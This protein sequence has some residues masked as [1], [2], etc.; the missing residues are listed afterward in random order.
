MT[1]NP[2]AQSNVMT[3]AVE[4][5]DWLARIA[6]DSVWFFCGACGDPTSWHVGKDWT[7]H[8]WVCQVCRART[9]VERA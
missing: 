8:V 6:P 4:T 3:G 9:E 2:R 1:T 7:R 5:T